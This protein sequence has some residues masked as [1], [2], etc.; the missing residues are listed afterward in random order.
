MHI[1]TPLCFAAFQYESTL[2]VSTNFIT[3][4]QKQIIENLNKSITNDVT[5]DSAHVKKLIYTL[6]DKEDL[7]KRECAPEKVHFVKGML[8]CLIVS[9][10][11]RKSNDET[12]LSRRIRQ[13]FGSDRKGDRRQHRRT[14]TKV[15][16]LRIQNIQ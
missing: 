9:I 10:Q 1:F 3:E 13:A 16:H 5:N 4:D 14:E 15:Y 11:N 2:P 7:Q 6:C 8:E 12:I